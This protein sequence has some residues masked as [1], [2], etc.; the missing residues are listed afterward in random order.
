MRDDEIGEM[1]RPDAIMELTDSAK[2]AKEA[3]PEKWRQ[4]LLRT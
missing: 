2:L 1:R 4:E 3:R